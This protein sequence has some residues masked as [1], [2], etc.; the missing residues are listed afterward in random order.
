M[1]RTE[2]GLQG[3]LSVEQKLLTRR[4]WSTHPTEGEP[5]LKCSTSK[6]VKCDGIIVIFYNNIYA[7]STHV[8]L[9]QFTDISLNLQRPILFLFLIPLSLWLGMRY[10][11]G[12]W[13]FL[14]HFF[15][16]QFLFDYI[17]VGFLFVFYLHISLSRTVFFLFDIFWV[18]D[19]MLTDDLPH[20]VL[21]ACGRFGLLPKRHFIQRPSLNRKHWQIFKDQIIADVFGDDGSRIFLFTKEFLL[22]NLYLFLNIKMLFRL[23]LFGS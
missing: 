22:E 2:I 16:H 1:N 9:P 20:A 23:N 14:V 10:E 17:F 4:G 18:D 3:S 11:E 15:I 7:W 5:S 13:L 12:Q 6:A 19:V 21:P 8:L